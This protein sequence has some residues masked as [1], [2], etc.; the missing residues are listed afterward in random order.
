MK[1]NKTY[2]ISFWLFFTSHLIN[3][4]P[5]VPRLNSLSLH[6]F[7]GWQFGTNG[8]LAF[9]LKL[10]QVLPRTLTFWWAEDTEDHVATSRTSNTSKAAVAAYWKVLERDPRSVSFRR[11][12]S[13]RSSSHVFLDSLLK[14]ELLVFFLIIKWNKTRQSTNK[15]LLIRNL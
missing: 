3:H 15:S 7:D 5:R 13:L 11:S 14:F 9:G 2:S 6:R 10:R 8:G 1:I 12:A 4:T